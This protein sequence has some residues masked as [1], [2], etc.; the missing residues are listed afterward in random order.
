MAPWPGSWGARIV[1]RPGKLTEMGW[2]VEP[3]GL[4]WMLERVGREHPGLPLYDL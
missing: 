4:T 1:E 2:G 3:E